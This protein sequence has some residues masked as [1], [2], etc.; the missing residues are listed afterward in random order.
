MK[1]PNGYGTIKKLS[2]NRRCP[3]V[4]VLTID[5]KQKPIEYFSKLIDAEIFQAH[6]SQKRGGITLSD[7][8]SEIYIE[9]L[10]QHIQHFHPSKSAI[11][12]Y[13]NAFKHCDKIHQLPISELKYTHYQSIID[14]IRA[15]GLSY[16]SAKKVKSF[17]SL[18]EKYALK[19][20]RISKSYV[21]L[22][23]IGTNQK[24]YPHTIF[25]RQQINKLW[26]I[27]YDSFVDTILILLYTGIR[28]GELL[29]LQ[30]SD[31]NLKQKYIHIKKAK[32][33]SGIR[34][35]PIHEKILPFIYARVKTSKKYFI[36]KNGMPLPYSQYRHIWD[37]IMK[38][39]KINHRPH[40][41]RHTVATLLDN[42]GANENAKRKILGHASGD[43]TDRVY[44][45][46]TLPQLRKTIRLLK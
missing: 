14:T 23:T 44:T 40:D 20:D 30:K 4:F 43:V 28:V 13:K 42:Y 2:G 38:E 32:T 22:V 19:T 21:S 29:A 37:K 27:K 41:T 45:H 35:I 25:T 46:K 16:S 33:L 6:Y 39:L 15:T 31:I 26:C 8:F 24:V 9:W 10:S 12:S 7:T 5:H 18:I 17:L 3:Y 34:I 1:K 36:E 11:L